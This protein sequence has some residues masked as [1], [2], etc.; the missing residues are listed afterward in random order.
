[1]VVPWLGGPPAEL[2]VLAV[3]A[4]LEKRREDW[5]RRIAQRPEELQQPFADFDPKRLLEN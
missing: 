3:A 1:M 2:F 4:P 5:V